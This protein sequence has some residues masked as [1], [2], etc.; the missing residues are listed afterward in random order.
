MSDKICDDKLCSELELK[1]VQL[2]I[3]SIAYFPP[4]LKQ[5][6]QGAEPSNVTCTEGKELVLKQSHG[7]PT[8]INP[9]SVEKLIARVETSMFYLITMMKITLLKFLH[10]KNLSQSLKL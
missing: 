8:C 1:T 5:I 10:L 4:P 7:L 3:S 9:S 2:I 6:S